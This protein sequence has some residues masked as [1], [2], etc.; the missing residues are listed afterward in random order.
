MADGEKLFL[1]KDGFP[2]LPYSSLS[3][4]PFFRQPLHPVFKLFTEFDFALQHA[5]RPARNAVALQ[6]GA[7]IGAEFIVF[8]GKSHFPLPIN[9]SAFLPG[10]ILKHGPEAW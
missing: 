9:D 5:A 7:A 1:H 10:S 6:L 3:L 2:A 4:L 8:A